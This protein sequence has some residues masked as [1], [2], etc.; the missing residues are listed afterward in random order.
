MDDLDSTSMVSANGQST[1]IE[2]YLYA[3]GA[4]K[5]AQCEL[6]ALPWS[7]HDRDMKLSSSSLVTFRPLA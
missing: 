7:S 5:W 4:K 6:N 3:A 2:S 1:M